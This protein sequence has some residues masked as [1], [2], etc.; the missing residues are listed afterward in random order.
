MADAAR[1]EVA[2]LLRRAAF[3]CT[4]AEL[5]AAAARGYEATVEELTRPSAANEPAPPAGSRGPAPPSGGGEPGG[6]SEPARPGAS[7]ESAAPGAGSESARP[8]GG[9]EPAPPE[10]PVLERGDG[11]G[12]RAQVAAL[13]SWWLDLMVRTRRPLVERLTLCWHGHWATS[14]QKV[15][16]APLMLRQNQTLRT[17]GTGDFREL[18][19]A[20]V[21]DPAML[22]WLDAGQNRPASPNENLA[23]EL[24][25]LF[26][27]G[28]GNY[29]DE[30]VK[31][32]ARAL[33]GWRVNRQTGAA[34]YVAQQH[35]AKPK[36]ILGRTAGYDDRSLVDMLVDTDASHR[37]VLRRLWFRLASPTPPDDATTGRLLT[38]YGQGRDIDAMLKALLLDPTF[39]AEPVRHAL[40]SEPI[41]YA[42]AAMRALGITPSTMAAKDQRALLANLRGMG[43]EPFAPPSVGGW[44]ANRGW[45]A[46]SAA[47]T[48]L[49]L[50]RRLATHA[51]LADIDGTARTDRVD[52]TAHLLSVESWST[53]TR[54]VLT[55]AAGDPSQLVALALASPEYT[56]G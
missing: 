10:L 20:M 56:V 49:T 27:L 25:E 28:I 34:R 21:R 44:P 1:A 32:A 26:V 4:A 47:Q 3:G 17:L 13:Q 54:T 23:R 19:R 41:V 16:S 36:T 52:A 40:V 39:R 37:F 51:D 31:Q 15:R 24:M 55:E 53:R 42:V 11:K 18:A 6:G 48:R 9:G 14:V 22:I 8:G 7:S 43:Q 12:R 2:H 29:T 5:D 35:D 50:A 38:A 33:T 30:D 46:T 45:L